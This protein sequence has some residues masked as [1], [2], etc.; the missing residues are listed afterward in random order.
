MYKA[1]YISEAEFDKLFYRNSRVT[2]E[3]NYNPTTKDISKAIICDDPIE[4]DIIPDKEI[5]NFFNEE[6]V[7]AFMSLKNPQDD[8]V[9]VDGGTFTLTIIQ[10]SGHSRTVEAYSEDFFCPQIAFFERYVKEIR[11]R[12][13]R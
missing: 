6:N 2:I 10:P 8:Y 5:E 11:K 4:N 3:V 9:V 13:N 12:T 7:S 1:I